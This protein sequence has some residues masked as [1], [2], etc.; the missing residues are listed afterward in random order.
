[1]EFNK[2]CKFVEVKAGTKGNY[3][4]VT[5]TD[6]TS[7]NI[8][9]GD[10]VT[11]LEESRLSNRMLAVE[12]APNP[13]NPKYMN[14]TSMDWAGVPATEPTPD[15]QFEQLGREQ[16]SKGDVPKGGTNTLVADM[17]KADWDAKQKIERKSIERQTAL[18]AAVE[19]AITTGD[20]KPDEIV[21]M[22][23]RFEDYLEGKPTNKL[24]R[25]V[26]A[27]LKLGAE[28]TGEEPKG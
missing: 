19:V 7:D 24:G 21:L 6:N 11:I 28:I 4:K 17:S 5:W 23:M 25:L 1:M 22:A 13:S 16:N 27:A 14:I 9:K 10:W 2:I 8:F 3:W 18:K 15:A 12:K 26:E 20:L